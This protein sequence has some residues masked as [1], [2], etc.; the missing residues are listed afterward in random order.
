MYGHVDVGCLHVRPALN[1]I[2]PSHEQ[3]IRPITERVRNLVTRYGGLIWGEH[4][5]GFRSEFLPDVLGSVLM[6]EVQ[7]LKAIAD[8]FGQCNPGKWVSPSP[9]AAPVDRLE[10]PLRVFCKSRFSSRDIRR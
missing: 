5:K 1:L 9:E 3:L 2:N 10:V 6:A 4:G 7:K 8:P